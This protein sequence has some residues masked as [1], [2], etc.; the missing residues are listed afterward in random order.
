MDVTR[1]TAGIVCN[2]KGQGNE[3]NGEHAS[4]REHMRRAKDAPEEEYRS[5]EGSIYNGGA[6]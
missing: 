6:I 1:R 5:R 3:L 2:S 4:E